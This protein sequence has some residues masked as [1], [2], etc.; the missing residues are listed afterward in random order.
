MARVCTADRLGRLQRSVV[1][2]GGS[3]KT[4]ADADKKKEQL[5]AVYNDRYTTGGT[6]EGNTST[7][8]WRQ[9]RDAHARC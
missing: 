6:G 8:S 1:V 7:Y 4:N 3:S 9:Y 5:C 2:S